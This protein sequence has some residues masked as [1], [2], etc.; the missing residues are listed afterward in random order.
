METAL[1]H[2]SCTLHG[3]ASNQSDRGRPVLVI[4]FAAAD[5]IPYTAAPYPSS[6]Y[7]KLVRGKEPRF[8]HHEELSVPLPPDWSSGY[9]S[10]YAHQEETD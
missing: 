5:A 1:V 10:I 9:T 7:G 6:H 4:T 3:S 2:H 8:A